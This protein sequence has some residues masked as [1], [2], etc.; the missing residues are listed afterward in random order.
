MLPKQVFDLYLDQ[1]LHEIGTASLPEHLGDIE[2]G[3]LEGPFVLQID[4]ISNV[5]ASV[6]QKSTPGVNLDNKRRLCKMYITDGC[7]DVMGI[8]T[9]FIK[10][11]SVFTDAGCKMLVQNVQIRRGSMLLSPLCVQILYGEVD[12][13]VAKQ[14]KTTVI[15]SSSSSASYASA[16][17]EAKQDSNVPKP[18]RGDLNSL[19]PKRPEQEQ[20]EIQRQ[21]QQDQINHHRRNIEIEQRKQ[22]QENGATNV[23]TVEND[24]FFDEIEIEKYMEMEAVAM[25]KKQRS[26]ESEMKT[27]KEIVGAI[28]NPSNN[29]SD[30]KHDEGIHIEG[31]LLEEAEGNHVDISMPP[32]PSGSQNFIDL[33]TPPSTIDIE[34]NQCLDE[35]VIDTVNVLGVETS[36]LLPSSTLPGPELFS[37]Q[38]IEDEIDEML[39]NNDRTQLNSCH[40]F[41]KAVTKKITKFT[42]KKNCVVAILTVIDT[43]GTKCHVRFNSDLCE[44]IIGMT[45]SEYRK[46]EK[47]MS[48]EEKKKFKVEVCQNFRALDKPLLYTMRYDSDPEFAYTPKT[49]DL[50]GNVSPVKSEGDDNINNATINSGS[51]SQRSTVKYPLLIVK[52]SDPNS[53][54]GP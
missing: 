3:V 47:S 24:D 6:A 37:F 38:R 49:E 11:L 26:A 29:F 25:G 32:S 16:E 33:L 15:D 17:R 23:E 44:E 30:G 34:K 51:G 2:R 9:H 45:V 40:F 54:I 36:S 42:C 12:R 46:K 1:D 19:S 35:K 28:N 20:K 7:T 41:I 10:E 53:N 18:T 50:T 52:M 21:M 39:K 43:D 48:K 5:G 22:Q 8:E 4:E 13:L 31:R 14:K 27:N